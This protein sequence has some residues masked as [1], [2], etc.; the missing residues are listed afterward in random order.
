MHGTGPARQHLERRSLPVFVGWIASK[1]SFVVVRIHLFIRILINSRSNGVSGDGDGLHDALKGLAGHVR[2]VDASFHA[3]GFPIL[4]YFS[5]TFQWDLKALVMQMSV[6]EPT[7]SLV[8]LETYPPSN[9]FSIAFSP[10]VS[11]KEG[12]RIGCWV[13]YSRMVRVKT[14]DQALPINSQ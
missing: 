13:D 10:D 4:G 12:R 1:S 6:F 14:A 3:F 9:S 11:A 8:I 5:I 2:A 7:H